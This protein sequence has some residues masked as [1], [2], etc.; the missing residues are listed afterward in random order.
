M[1]KLQ[2][3]LSF[4]L[5]LCFNNLSA[6]AWQYHPFDSSSKWTM[7]SYYHSPN[8]PTSN[9]A[10]NIFINRDTIINN[11]TYKLVDEY[12]AWTSN[13]GVINM[14]G[15][16]GTSY[17][18]TFGQNHHLIGGIREDSLKRVYFYSFGNLG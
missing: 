7:V 16:L 13:T 1:Y 5:S 18:Q 3:L 2:F 14:G 17:H 12:S 15:Q 10:S 8:P 9:N 4:L 11:L 6:Q